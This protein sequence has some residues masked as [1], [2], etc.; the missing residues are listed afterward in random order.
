MVRFV[1]FII[2]SINEKLSEE[3]RSRLGG[4]IQKVYYYINLSNKKTLSRQ[5]I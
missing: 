3:P 4:G 5:G 2:L 1:F